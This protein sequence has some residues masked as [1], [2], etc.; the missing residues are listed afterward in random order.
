MLKQHRYSFL[1]AVHIER[2]CN[3]IPLLSFLYIPSFTE[4]TSKKHCGE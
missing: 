3:S 2:K 1:F 4:V